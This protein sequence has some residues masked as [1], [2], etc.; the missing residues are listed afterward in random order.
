MAIST[1]YVNYE[2]IDYT[3]DGPNAFPIVNHKSPED[4]AFFHKVKWMVSE[5]PSIGIGSKQLGHV[6]PDA[7]V[8]RIIEFFAD[9]Y[10]DKK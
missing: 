2:L 9:H 1:H 4:M 6:L 10:K 7:A 5:T 8:Q 3:K